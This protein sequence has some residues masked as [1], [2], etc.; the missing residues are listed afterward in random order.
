MPQLDLWVLF[1]MVAALL[2]ERSDG[3]MEGL[4]M[5][6]RAFKEFTEKETFTCVACCRQPK[7]T[8]SGDIT[9]WLT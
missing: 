2:V 5:G 3:E 1:W 6:L 7:K 4:E 8:K 9:E